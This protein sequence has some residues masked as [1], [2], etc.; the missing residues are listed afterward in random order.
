MKYPNCAS[1]NI[2]IPYPNTDGKWF[3]GY[4]DQKAAMV[5]L[6]P[7]NVVTNDSPRSTIAAT[8]SVSAALNSRPKQK[9]LPLLQFYEAG[10]H[11][12]CRQLRKALQQNYKCTKEAQRLGGGDNIIPS[13]VIGYHK[14]TF[15]PCPGGDSP[16]AKR[17]FDALHAGCI[18]V[19]LSHDFVWPFLL[20]SNKNEEEFSIRLDA[21]EYTRPKFNQQCG[22]NVDATSF[23]LNRT[24][25]PSTASTGTTSTTAA[26]DL[27][28]YLKTI[29]NGRIQKLKNGVDVASDYYAYYKRDKH[30]PDNPLRDGVL[31]N[32]GAAHALVDKLGVRACGVLWP[33]CQKEGKQTRP[34]E[35][36]KV[37][38][39]KC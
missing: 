24:T 14:A 9:Q 4:Y 15:C 35:T 33:A 32:G 19:V 12:T 16:S 34:M 29:P 22:L 25:N 21:Q 28:S 17:F 3:N 36:D 38:S 13:F 6:L 39:F 31:P 1:K 7:N 23:P 18:P 30:L 2:L 20:G 5:E 37:N 26:L 11:G 10:N 8:S 27:H